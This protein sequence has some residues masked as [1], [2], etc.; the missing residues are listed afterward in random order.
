MSTKDEPKPPVVEAAQEAVEKEIAPRPTRTWRTRVFQGYL[1]TAIILFLLLLIGASLVDYFPIDLSITRGV[2]YF[3]AGWF[4][5]LM[6]AV[7]YIGY[8]PQAWVLVIILVILLY[9]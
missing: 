3:N 8:A 6:G 4:G 5:I 1:I 9:L 7:S 2:Q